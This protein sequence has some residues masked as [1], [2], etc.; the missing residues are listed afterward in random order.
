MF[1]GLMIL[2]TLSIVSYLLVLND[3]SKAKGK[4]LELTSKKFVP[5][6][7]FLAL[8]LPSGILTFVLNASQLVQMIGLVVLL[9]FY[10]VIIYWGIRIELK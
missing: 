5:I 1:V 3:V 2:F 10:S 7:V 8:S 6:I 9:I 4:K